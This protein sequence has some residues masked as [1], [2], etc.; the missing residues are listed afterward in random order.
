MSFG[1]THYRSGGT[2]GGADQFSWTDVKNDKHREYYLGHSLH[3]SVGRWQA[4][5]DLTWYTK[6]GGAAAPGSEADAVAEE[7]KRVAAME[8]HMML[9]ALGLEEPDAEVRRTD[10]LDAA[11]IAAVLKRGQLERDDKL[12]ERA[13]GLG[14]APVRTHDFIAGQSAVDRRVAAQMSAE[15]DASEDDAAAAAAAAALPAEVTAEGGGSIAERREA[16]AALRSQLLTTK[17]ELQARLMELQAKIDGRR[18]KKAKRRRE[19]KERRKRR[20]RRDDDSEGEDASDYEDRERAGSSRHRD[21]SR[22]R[23][24][25]SRRRR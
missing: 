14:A 11:D 19:R 18:E 24:R 1:R 16:I 25:R 23:S 4:G 12:G 21:R 6:K 8:K 9:V 2:R 10:E 3:A 15:L 7:R 13:E 5:K 22:E 20:R 17:A